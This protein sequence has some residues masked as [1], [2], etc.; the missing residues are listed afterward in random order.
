MIIIIIFRG[1][2]C[3]CVRHPCYWSF[4]CVWDH[5]VWLQHKDVQWPVSWTEE[6]KLFCCCCG[7]FLQP[8]VQSVRAAPYL[9]QTGFT[10]E[11]CCGV[12]QVYTAATGVLLVFVYAA[13]FF[14]KSLQVRLGPPKILRRTFEVFRCKIFYRSDAFSVSQPTAWGRRIQQQWVN[15]CDGVSPSYE[16]IPDIILIGRYNNINNEKNKKWNFCYI[17]G[18]I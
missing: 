14:L 4:P 1:C 17:S 18:V 12:R 11:L 9:W 16:H 7:T 3:C 8:V 15:N 5:L 10:E 13:Y 2:C 6:V